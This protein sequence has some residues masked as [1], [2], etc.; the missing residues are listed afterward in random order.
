MST[1]V[2][3]MARDRGGPRIVQQI[4]MCPAVHRNFSPLTYDKEESPPANMSWAWQQY[5]SDEADTTNP[6]A[7]PIHA[8][9][10]GLPPA[11][12]ITAEYDSLRDEGE[13]YA[14]KLKQ[15]GVATISKRYEG[16]VHVF[17]MYPVTLTV[18]G[19]PLSKRWPPSRPP[20]PVN[21]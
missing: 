20:S 16:M 5:L 21:Q 4:V 13:A 12:V 3:L 19:R 1:V 6:Y 14:E 11:L 15:A 18:A 2:C 10:R 7:C 17:H 9:L 8:D